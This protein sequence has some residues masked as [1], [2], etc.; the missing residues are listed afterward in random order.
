MDQPQRAH[1]DR[2]RLGPQDG[3]SGEAGGGKAR[4]GEKTATMDH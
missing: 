4:T 3:G 2:A 1:L